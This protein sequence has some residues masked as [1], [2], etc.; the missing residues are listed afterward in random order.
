MSVAEIT[1]ELMALKDEKYK[2]FHSSLIPGIDN[3]LGVRAPNVKSLAKKYANTDTGKDFLK[4]LP[5]TYYDENMLHGYML[6]F[7]KEDTD[8][9]KALLEKFL[10]YVNNWAVCD[11]MV[12]NLKKFFKNPDNVYGFIKEIAED[13]REYHIRFALV[14]MLNYYIDRAHIDEVLFITSQIK[15]ERYYV[16]MAQAWLISVALVKEYERAVKLLEGNILSVWVHNKSIQKA[17]ESFRISDEQ[18]QYLSSL[19]R[20]E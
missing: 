4:A 11:S 5:H 3:I 6:G 13:K 1:K 2:D 14:S 20:K 8:S 12:S 7:L 15:D 9:V 16:K 19:K 10:P 18:K 17:K